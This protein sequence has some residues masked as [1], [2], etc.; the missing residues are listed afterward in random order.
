MSVK[1]GILPLVA[2]LCLTLGAGG[3][4]ASD[5]INSDSDPV[6]KVKVEKVKVEKVKVEKVKPQ[7]KPKKRAVPEIDAASGTQALA[8][9]CGVLLI[10]AERLRRR[11]Q[12]AG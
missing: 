7:K 8:L 6:K 11:P 9:V 2:V 4:Y 5:R 10:G 1:N 3:A 12:R